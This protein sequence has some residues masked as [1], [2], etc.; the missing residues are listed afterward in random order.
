[1]NA[2][3]AFVIDVLE[4]AG[5]TFLQGAAASLAGSHTLDALGQAHWTEAGQGATAAALAG[6][7]ALLSLVTSVLS[8][9]RTGTASTS[10]V[11]AESTPTAAST[12]THAAVI[13][14]APTPTETAPTPL[15]PFTYVLTEQGV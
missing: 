3:R 6:G 9:L 15:P 11:V 2:T 7:M 12:G 5:K 8:G 4:R 1:M 14:S 10:L 13:P